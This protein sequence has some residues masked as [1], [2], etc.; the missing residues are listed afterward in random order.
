M[1]GGASTGPKTAEGLERSRKAPWKHGRRSAAAI[2]KAKVERKKKN[3]ANR[4]IKTE[5]RILERLV[6]QFG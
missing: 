1:H 3:A 4:Q 6:R 5:L 2:A